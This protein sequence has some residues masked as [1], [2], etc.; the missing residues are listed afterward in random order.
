MP[1]FSPDGFPV[2]TR[3]NAHSPYTAARIT[4]KV[5]TIAYGRS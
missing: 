5:A 2:N 4:P 3:W 1:M